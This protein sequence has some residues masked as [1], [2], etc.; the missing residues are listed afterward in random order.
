MCIL[1]LG[2]YFLSGSLES[3]IAVC[4]LFFWPPQLV[5]S[6]GVSADIRCWDAAVSGER[7]VRR[8]WSMG[9]IVHMGRGQGDM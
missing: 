4:C 1:F 8:G 7:L 5:Y 9:S 6:Q 2:F 3:V